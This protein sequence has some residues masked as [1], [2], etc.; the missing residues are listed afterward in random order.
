M[1]IEYAPTTS[2]Y[3]VGVDISNVFNT[4]NTGPFFNGRFQP[5]ATGLGG[6]L[7]GFSAVPADFT[8][9]GGN[10][11][12]LPIVHGGEVFLNSPN[13]FPRTFFFY[14]RVRV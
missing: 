3:A 7:T 12:Y 1:T 10:P 6:P 5:L 11:R 2:K 14:A 8:A 9:A 13:G 4:L